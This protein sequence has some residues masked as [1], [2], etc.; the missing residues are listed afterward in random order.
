[1]HQKLYNFTGQLMDHSNM[2]MI[3]YLMRVNLF[4]I[5]MSFRSKNTKFKTKFLMYKSFKIELG[6]CM[7]SKKYSQPSTDNMLSI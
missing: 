7:I 1:M 5:W 6:I 2:P 3:V 4:T